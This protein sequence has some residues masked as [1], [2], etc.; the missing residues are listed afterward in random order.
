L[1][2]RDSVASDSASPA[3]TIGIRVD[4]SVWEATAQKV[5]LHAEWRI[6]S[7]TAATPFELQCDSDFRESTSGSPGDM[8]RA[9]Q[10]LLEDLAKSIAPLLRID[11]PTDCGPPA[12]AMAAP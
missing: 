12:T 4:I 2:L 1:E 8:V 6:R 7:H 3:S 5:Y 9:D 11:H 10:A